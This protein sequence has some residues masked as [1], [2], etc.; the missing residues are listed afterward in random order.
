MFFQLT[1]DGLVTIAVVSDGV[2]CRLEVVASAE[3]A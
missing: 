2:E 1:V 3:I